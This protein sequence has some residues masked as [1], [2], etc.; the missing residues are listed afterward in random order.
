[1]MYII[2]KLDIAVEL[3]IKGV[4]E[5]IICKYVWNEHQGSP[6]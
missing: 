3:K 6:L 1:M 5:C 2:L 4:K